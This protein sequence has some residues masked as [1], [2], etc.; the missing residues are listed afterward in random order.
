[1]IIRVKA[2]KAS[3]YFLIVA[4]PSNLFLSVN[5]TKTW[6]NKLFSGK[7]WSFS[8]V[9]M[10]ESV[11]IFRVLLMAWKNQDWWISALLC[12]ECTSVRPGAG[13]NPKVNGQCQEVLFYFLHLT[14]IL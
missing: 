2:C 4:F 11:P 9:S 1:L 5:W 3:V 7:P 12:D 6:M 14:P 8:K 13:W 10:T